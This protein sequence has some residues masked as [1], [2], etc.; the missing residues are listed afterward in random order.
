MSKKERDIL[1]VVKMIQK[2]SSSVLDATD[3]FKFRLKK[4]PVF[5]GGGQDKDV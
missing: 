2:A 4:P 3:Q 1:D 5:G